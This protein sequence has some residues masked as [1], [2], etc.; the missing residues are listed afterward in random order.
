MRSGKNI[1]RRSRPAIFFG[2]TIAVGLGVADRVPAQQVDRPEAAH[3]IQ[4]ALVD[5][6]AR[7]E[8][9]VVAIARIVKDSEFL[10]LR[11]VGQFPV[12]PGQTAPQ[13]TDP[14]FIP[15]EYGT[16]VII[17]RSGLILTNYHV[18]GR[19]DE[20]V[21]RSRYVITTVTG[22]VYERVKIKA[23]DLWSDLAVLEVEADDLEPIALGDTKGLKKGQL[24]VALGNPYAIARDG[25]ASASWGI[26]SNLFRKAGPAPG[27]TL[28]SGKD[29]MH[30]YGT[31]IQTDAR[32]NLGTSGGALLNLDGEMIGLTTSLAARASYE[33]AAGYAIPVDDAFK[34]IV[35]ALK[36][37]REVEYGFL[38]VHP[39]N[40][41]AAE[42]LRGWQG[43]RV[44]H[45][46]GATPAALADLRPGD[47]ISHVDQV[48]LRDADGLMLLIGREPVERSVRLTVHRDQRQ[49][50]TSVRL[51]KKF[52]YSDRNSIA[53]VQVPLWRGLE[54]DYPTALP[55]FKEKSDSG[56]VDPDGCVAVVQVDRDSRGWQDGMR[57][58]VFI[59]HVGETRVNSPR[60]FRAAVAGQ[61]GPVTFR[62]TSPV[63]GR[64]TFTVWP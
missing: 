11:G 49:F 35:Q 64:M 6:I 15:N 41:T 40:L 27:T 2:L 62:L 37:G 61:D 42:R 30:H 12:V 20:Q 5:A 9:S 3:I 7:S 45:I 38:G 26:I 25:Q 28:P 57:R 32:L 51:M 8:R 16:G 34:R 31:L 58:G 19:D 44:G 13:P 52:I 54:I 60:Q 47:V 59:S 29:T 21:S 50:R 39:E 53:T 63:D 46:V 22:K 33:M 48:P 10:A 4:N 36:E 55:D 1:Q 56:Q 43:A 18:L 24:V 23:A 14:D 17:D